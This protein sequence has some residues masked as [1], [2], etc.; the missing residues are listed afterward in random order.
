MKVS[1]IGDK[2]I[3]VC[4]ARF[5]K[6]KG[7]DVIAFYDNSIE[8]SV[9]YAVAVSCKAYI[10][11]ERAVSESELIVIAVNDRTLKR[12]MRK[13]AAYKPSGKIFCALTAAETSEAV[14]I[15][16]NNT[17][18]TAFI[19]K[20]ANDNG[21]YAD[22]SDAPMFFEGFGDLYHDFYD[23]L[24]MRGVKAKFIDKTQKCGCTL[25]AA[26]T[27]DFVGMLCSIACDVSQK[28]NVGEGWVKDFAAESVYK[29]LVGGSTNDEFSINM[30]KAL[31]GISCLDSDT[32]HKLKSA[33]K[34]L[35]V[36]SVSY[37]N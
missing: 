35:E 22:I 37:F 20:Y 12:T 13:I 2:K 4:F 23:E 7:F 1:V 19:P 24:Y 10:D 11:L 9:K 5:L 27:S 14:S 33:I 16:G 29:A 26:L 28:V 32:V 21:D 18:F 8:T 17:Y 15:G 6:K 34:V 25:A 31:S 3:G 36:M 30:K